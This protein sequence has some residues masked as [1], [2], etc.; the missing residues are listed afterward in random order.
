MVIKDDGTLVLTV[1][2]TL[3]PGRDD[4][5]IALVQQAPPRGMASAIRE[6][7]RSGI[8]SPAATE[9]D[10]DLALPDLGVDL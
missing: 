5:L 8:T 3:K 9:E 4:D 10:D 6:A 1:R 7:M 2:V